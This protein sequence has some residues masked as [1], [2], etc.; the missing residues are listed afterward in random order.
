MGDLPFNVHE[1][2]IYGH[3]MG[4]HFSSDVRPLRDQLDNRR[5][6]P[7]PDNSATKE[8]SHSRMRES[9]EQAQRWAVEDSYAR[10][11]ERMRADKE[12]QLVDI[13]V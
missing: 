1:T 6:A 9:Y 13:Y 10:M 7:L 5:V 12:A 3:Q 11:G 4:P 8:Y 2:P